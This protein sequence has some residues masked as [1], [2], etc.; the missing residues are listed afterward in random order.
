MDKGLQ[1]LV[2][3]MPY[4]G[5]G[6]L[7]LNATPRNTI[8]RGFARPQRRCYT[9]YLLRCGP[10]CSDSNE[11]RQPERRIS[12]AGVVKLADTLG[13]GPSAFTGVG[14]QVPSPAPFF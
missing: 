5:S 10:R 3:A 4:M 8:W 14:V 7:H 6:F 9:F 13:S 11:G 12:G 1:P 2:C